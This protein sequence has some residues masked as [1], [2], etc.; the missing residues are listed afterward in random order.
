MRST[1]DMTK[2]QAALGHGCSGITG[3]SFYAAYMEDVAVFLSRGG[4]SHNVLWGDKSAGAP[5]PP[6]TSRHRICQITKASPA[7]GSPPHLF[8]DCGCHNL[9]SYNR[10]KDSRFDS[11][12]SVAQHHSGFAERHYIQAC[13]IDVSRKNYCGDTGWN[14]GGVKG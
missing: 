2:K 4:Q 12:P 3:A 7:S 8:R 13:A 10:P 5:M 1:A 6:I 9:V 11:A 14:S